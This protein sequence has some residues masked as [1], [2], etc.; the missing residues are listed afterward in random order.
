[1]LQ[2][3]TLSLALLD[4]SSGRVE[5]LPTFERGKKIS[6]QWAADGRRVYFLSDASG[7]TDVYVVE[8]ADGKVNRVTGLDAGASGITALS[9]ALS[10]SLDANRL[11]FS[12][13]E[14][15]RIGVYVI[16]KREA[17]A[18]TPVEQAPALGNAAYCHPRARLREA[19][20]R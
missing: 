7:L 15:G 2:A 5:A 9:P 20:R 19:R 3:G 12:A 17:L 18:G 6:P 16:D 1:M 14:E 10:T 11:A 13:Y 8:I 4:V